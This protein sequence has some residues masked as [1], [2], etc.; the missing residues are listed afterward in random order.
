MLSVEYRRAPEHPFPTPL[1]DAYA[2]LRWLHD[3]AAALGVD[4]LYLLDVDR[5][6]PGQE[7][8]HAELRRV[9]VGRAVS[10]G[11]RPH[12]AFSSRAG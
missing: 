6:D 8:R 3:N 2:A 12:A 7:E 11:E 9:R 5:D 4:P 10:G 1:E